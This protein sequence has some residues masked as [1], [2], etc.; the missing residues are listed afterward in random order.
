[1]NCFSFFSLKQYRV[2]KLTRY[3]HRYTPSLRT[4]QL[5]NIYPINSISKSLKIHQ[6]PKNK[7]IVQA[8]YQ[9][10]LQDY[11][12]ISTSRMQRS[13]S[14]NRHITL[15]TVPNCNKFIVIDGNKRIISL[16][17][18]L[19]LLTLEYPTIECIVYQFTDP[20]HINLFHRLLPPFQ[21]K[22]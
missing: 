20:T 10:H 16:F 22:Y 9:T 5:N 8:F 7:K 14:C 18:L 15:V 4:I 11:T 6:H 21:Y 17:Q 13:L 19:D 1:M 3:C 12:F 2:R